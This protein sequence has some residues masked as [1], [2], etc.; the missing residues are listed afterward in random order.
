MPPLAMILP[1]VPLLGEH[2][3]PIIVEDSEPSSLS[4]REF[5]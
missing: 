4:E 1:G 2:G 5:A 3:N